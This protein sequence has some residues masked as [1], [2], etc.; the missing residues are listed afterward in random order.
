[1]YWTVIPERGAAPVSNRSTFLI[2]V[3]TDSKQ[4]RLKELAGKPE[5][6]WKFERV[7]Y[8]EVEYQECRSI[9]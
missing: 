6:A 3:L 5:Q 2:P 8:H 9:Q 7:G 1:M 4:V